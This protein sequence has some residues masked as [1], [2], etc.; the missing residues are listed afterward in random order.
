MHIGMNSFK[1]TAGGKILNL[2][3]FNP[4]RFCTPQQKKLL[5]EIILSKKKLLE[6]K[7]FG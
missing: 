5:S 7:N 4:V 2:V 3:A 6:K 1:K